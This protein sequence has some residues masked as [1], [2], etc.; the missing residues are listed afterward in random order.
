MNLSLDEIATQANERLD[1]IATQANKRPD[2]IATQ[3]NKRLDGIA[4]NSFHNFFVIEPSA[5]G[6]PDPQS[7]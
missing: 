7:K 5:R 1:E 6:T 2:G 4:A 3:T